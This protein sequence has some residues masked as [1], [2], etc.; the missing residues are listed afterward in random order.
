[1]T[2]KPG[3]RLDFSLTAF[4]F[5]SRDRVAPRIHV[6]EEVRIRPGH[7]V[8]DFGCGPGSYVVPA[9]ELVGDAGRVYALDCN[10]LAVE[11]VARRARAHR[12]GNV[13]PVLSDCKTGLADASVDVV[14]L[15]DTL[16]DWESP[17]EVLEELY[18]VSKPGGTLSVSDHHPSEAEIVASV[19][20]S[21]LFALARRGAKTH[22][23]L[24]A[25]S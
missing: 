2:T 24:S 9:A 6:L 11:R 3:R 7:R 17:I 21:G 15:Y 14:L 5:A 22:S 1:M 13:E 4:M 12:L 20:A 18:R 8:L 23:F 16:H 25:S 19:T 10:P